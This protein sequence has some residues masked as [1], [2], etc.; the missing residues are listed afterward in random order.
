MLCSGVMSIV[1]E[2][3]P[4]V[5]E[6]VR[7]FHNMKIISDNMKHTNDVLSIVQHTKSDLFSS[8]NGNIACIFDV[9]KADL[10]RLMLQIDKKNKEK[11]S[12]S[13]TRPIQIRSLASESEIEGKTKVLSLFKNV[14]ELSTRME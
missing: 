7:D 1:A 8:F 3:Q 2:M 12:G 5:L 6:Q 11:K 14:T 9:Y 4:Q 10:N 13:S